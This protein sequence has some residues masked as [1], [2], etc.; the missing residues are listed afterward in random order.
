MNRAARRA[1]AATGGDPSKIRVNIVPSRSR[2]NKRFGRNEVTHRA[3][4]HSGYNARARLT[5]EAAQFN[6]AP[7]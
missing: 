1:L 5:I 2:K 7:E 4:D 6:N 3:C